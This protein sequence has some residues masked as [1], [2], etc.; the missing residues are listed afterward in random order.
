[1]PSYHYEQGDRPLEGY[2]I[3]YA[4]GRGGFGEV[5][6]ALS[7]A[8]REVALKAVQNFEDVELRGIGHC[9]NLKSR[10]L[11]MIF[12]VKR[13]ADGT[14]WVIM[15][16]V[17][18]PSLRELLD[19][20]PN[21]LGPEKAMYFIRELTRGV[22]YLHESG[23]VHRDLKPHNVFFEDGVVK[24]GDYS[25]SKAITQSHRSGHTMT[26]GSVHYM[27]PEISMG[28]YDKTVDIYALGV[29]LYEMLT[30]EPPFV[31]ESVGEVLMKHLNSEPDLSTIDGPLA[32]VIKKAMARDPAQRYQSAQEMHEALADI[33]GMESMDESVPAS[34]S[35]VGR[36][37]RPYTPSAAQEGLT[38]TF[39][40][41][42]AFRDTVSRIETD[43][44]GAPR[45]PP[46]DARYVTRIFLSLA[47]MGVLL[48][49]AT[50]LET[51]ALLSEERLLSLIA[52][53]WGATLV[54]LTPLVRLFSKSQGLRSGILSRVS[55][56]VPLLVCYAVW[57]ESSNDKTVSD[58]HT[59]AFITA[60]AASIVLF[61][62]RLFVRPNREGRVSVAYTLLVGMIAGVVYLL[63]SQST[64]LVVFTVATAIAGSLSAQLLSGDLTHTNN[65][66]SIGPDDDALHQ[67]SLASVG[68]EEPV[69]HVEEPV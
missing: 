49:A 26:V 19:E 67:S 58:L 3:Q 64:K 6:F 7:D 25:L 60:I 30:G 1:M 36:R 9:M 45:K 10:H 39:G 13:G 33:G 43:A 12:D 68:T 38:E 47:V 63:A 27:A 62:W 46:I 28:R 44:A 52:A 34:L 17:S 54:C 61:D 69:A 50:I 56:I 22:G 2:T 32:L 41:P 55:M 42:A 29:M 14:P 59:G 31:G 51:G 21:G 66:N 48:T 20:S 18:G 35:L 65:S 24:V 16:Y 11:V 8:G 53:T 23:I 37:T 15:E 4:I 5:Y 57:D 40:S